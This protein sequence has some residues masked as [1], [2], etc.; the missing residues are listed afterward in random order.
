MN[1]KY[2]VHY[3]PAA[4]QDLIDILNYIKQ[5]N[6]TAAH[7]LFQE[8]DEAISRLED[9]PKMG[10]T[11]KDL[12]LKSLN[13]RMLVINNYLVFYVIKDDIIEIRRIVHGKR[14]YSFI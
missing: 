6:P 4:Q 14:K 2:E 10:V 9:F 3:L 11:P 1:E 5:D 12:R 13:Y 8:I 7:M